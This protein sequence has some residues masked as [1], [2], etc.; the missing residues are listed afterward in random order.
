MFCGVIQLKLFETELQNQDYNFPSQIYRDWIN[1]WRLN[2]VR[3]KANFLWIYNIIY[4][5]IL[6]VADVK[7]SP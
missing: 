5:V 4:F 1:I 7:L 6:F 3:I 2:G